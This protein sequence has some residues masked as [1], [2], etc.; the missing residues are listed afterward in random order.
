[1]LLTWKVKYNDKNSITVWIRK[2]LGKYRFTLDHIELNLFFF[3]HAILTIL[4]YWICISWMVFS[5]LYIWHVEIFHLCNR[6]LFDYD[7]LAHQLTIVNVNKTVPKAFLF[8][9][10]PKVRPGVKSSWFSKMI[11]RGTAKL[12]NI[13]DQ[14]VN[15][16]WFCWENNHVHCVWLNFMQIS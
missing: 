4:L 11:I 14:N 16:L 15:I 10:K 6:T 1:M 5:V 8:F 13:F 7:S 3:P 12:M 2:E 9:E